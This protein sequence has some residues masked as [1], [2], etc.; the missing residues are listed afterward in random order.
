M[1]SKSNNNSNKE[2]KV[3]SIN[4][5]NLEEETWSV[6]DKYF[7]NKNVLISHHIDSFN[8]LI[9][10][11]L[12]KIIKEK[13]FQIKVNADWND[14]LKMYLKSYYVNFENFYISKPVIYENNGKLKK[15]Y[16]NMARLRNMT[17][18]S[19][20]YIDIKHRYESYDAKTNK[21][22]VHNYPTL[23]KFECGKIPIMLKSKFCVLSEQN[24]LTCE[25]MEEGEYDYG[26]Y[27]IVKGTEKAIIPQERKCENKIYCFEE[28]NKQSKYSH[29]CEISSVNSNE[30]SYIISTKVK[31]ASKK[32]KFGNSIKV[33]I[34]SVSIDI[35]LFILF[36]ALNVISDKD[37]IKHI[38]YDIN[39][40]NTKLIE[41]LN[42]SINDARLITTQELALKYI[43]KYITTVRTKNIQESSYLI[44]Y[45]YNKLLLMIF[46]HLGRNTVK[47]A[48]FLGKMVNKLLKT[49]LGMLEYDDRDSFLN[50]KVETS[51]E[52]LAQLF[53]TY[54]SKFVKDI[55]SQLEKDVKLD[56]ISECGENLSKKFKVNDITTG[57]N[58][59]L[60][61]GNWGSQYYA[62]S[63]KGIAQLLPRLSYLGTL[64]TLRRLMA[65]IDRTGKQTEPRKLHPSQWGKICPYETPEGGS[66]G[67]VKNFSLMCVVTVPSNPQ[68]IY[69]CLEEFGVDL[70]ETMNPEDIYKSV[71]II[72]NGNW[73][74]QTFRPD[75]LTE[76]LKKMRRNGLIN[77]YTSIAW[78][79]K[80]NEISIRT[81]GGRMCRPLYVVKNNN[82][83]INKKNI[84][85]IK[86]K[87][88]NEILRLNI[89]CNNVLDCK[90][91]DTV[92]SKISKITEEE[93]N[94]CIIEYIDT[95]EENT[96]MIAMSQDKL[97]ENNINKKERGVYYNYTHCEIHPAMIFGVLATNIPFMNHN[98]APRNL[99]YS[100]MGKQ[101]IGVYSTAFKNRLDTASHVLY[102]P[103]KPL[104]STK[105]AKY[106]N[107]DVLP[108]GENCIIAIA[109]YTGYNQEDSLIFNKSSIDR[110]LMR[111]NYYRTYK[112][113]EKK[114]QSTL[115]DE[116]FTKPEKYNPDGT[117]KTEKMGFGS[118][119]K[120]NSDGFIKEGTFVNGNDYI[121]GKVIPLKNIRE[122]DC[123]YKDASTSLRAN[124]SGIVD[125]VYTN[126]NGEG[127]KFCKVRV[128]SERIPEIG[129]KFAS[130]HGQKGTI[131]MM[132]TQEDMPFTKDGV[133]PDIIMNPN[134]LPKRMTIGQLIECSFAKMSALY[135]VEFDATPFRKTNIRKAG[136]IL[137][138]LGFKKSGMEVLYNGKTGEQIKAD[139]FIGPTFYNRLKHLVK[140][141]IHSRSN[142]PM[143]LVTKQPTEGRARDGGLRFGEMERDCMIGYGTVH[144][145]KERMFDC[146]DKYCVWIDKET[147]MISPVNPQKNIY[148]SLYSDNTTRFAKVNIPY[149][150]KLLLHELQSMHIVPKINTSIM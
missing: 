141:K 112:D 121:I 40:S 15:M 126:R 32:G 101:A 90:D 48:F 39:P 127:Y 129:D 133:Y 37:I 92:C 31:M 6:I 2:T 93:N 24:G 20:F 51:G 143:Q 62:K 33:N 106:I 128:K 18:E 27:F 120:L 131:G 134:A 98:Q 142:G 146:S 78:N 44:K 83:L 69:S 28:K 89:D 113:E 13:D 59:S 140:D 124:E 77:I 81:D 21:M 73:Y 72:V 107:Q 75:K 64:S 102:Y 26:G 137:G 119:D 7:E 22:S 9:T 82:L 47:K 10:D 56:R 45:T 109:C 122:E 4:E 118:Y 130:R 110:G 80:K 1:E 88:W 42:E 117:F 8:Y 86:S 136:E 87:S 85:M 76:Y 35:P 115:E 5:F 149:S 16:P 61:T 43:S 14:E 41:L 135:G 58:Y 70:L 94:Q 30:P 68:V 97:L 60:A 123:K 138:E 11:D 55:K 105:T 147:G 66:V 95:D 74:A 116:K 150:S 103:Q 144:F 71:K 125:R 12:P 67:I 148:K 96:C 111:S 36:R 38:F 132:Y 108:S 52:L 139:I 3:N 49:Y 84:N 63:K 54:F 100:S 145:L 79:I 91:C 53:R 34:R 104:C 65:P 29:I 25:E 114:N 50:K 46:P 99:Y 19:I 57:L 17:Y 23:E